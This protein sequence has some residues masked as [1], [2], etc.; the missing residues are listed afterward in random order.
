V[1]YPD[2]R[3]GPLA[4]DINGIVGVVGPN[5]A[6][7]T[8][9]LSAVAGLLPNSTGSVAIDGHALSHLERR[10]D[11]GFCMP[12]TSF[13][14]QLT[15]EQHLRFLR[16]FY[17]NWSAKVETDLIERFNIP[18]RKKVGTASA[19]TVMKFSLLVALSRQPPAILLDEPWNTLDPI[20]R[21][22]L[23]TELF[24]LRE[25]TKCTIVISTHDLAQLQSIVQ[26]VVF[27]SEGRIVEV[28]DDLEALRDGSG[29]EQYYRGV[30]S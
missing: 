8:T 20:S 15:F 5:G 3:L 16:S 17:D 7:K 6:G 29:F 30:Y 28:K 27:L 13:H 24:R 22:E 18:R 12:P 25:E 9:L 26:R 23:S 11:V 2:F 14:F 1:R 4:L 10:R 21:F 19:G